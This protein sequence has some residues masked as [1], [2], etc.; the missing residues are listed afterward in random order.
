MQ[1]LLRLLFIIPAKKKKRIST[2]GDY[3]RRHHIK[4]DIATP[5]LAR[6]ETSE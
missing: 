1:N 3:E 6:Q 4:K 5:K 2:T